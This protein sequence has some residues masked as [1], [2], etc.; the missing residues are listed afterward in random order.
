MKKNIL[1]IVLFI[2]LTTVLSAQ[3]Q[4]T[5]GPYG[6]DVP[7][8]ATIG[9]TIIAA[10]STNGF[11]VSDDNGANWSRKSALNTPIFALASSGTNLFVSTEKGV[12]ISTNKGSTWTLANTGLP[13]SLSSPIYVGAFE[14]KGTTVYA[15]TD[16]GGVYMTTNNGANWTAINTGLPAFPSINVRTIGK[17][18]A[19]NLVI[20]LRPGIFLS[21]N[22]GTTWIPATIDSVRGGLLDVA[23]FVTKDSTTFAFSSSGIYKSITNGFTWQLINN[24][25]YYAGYLNSV[26]V[27]GS[28]IFVGTSTGVY[29]ST[30]NCVTWTPVGNGL[31]NK[32]VNALTVVGTQMFAGTQGGGVYKTLNNG[33]NWQISSN[34][35]TLNE[36]VGMTKIGSKLFAA[37]T[38]GGVFQNDST[39]MNWQPM[40]TGLSDYQSLIPV[41]SLMVNGSTL[42]AG[43]KIGLFSSTN[44]A[45]TWS[46]VNSTTPILNVTTL[47]VT[48]PLFIGEPIRLLAGFSGAGM[49]YSSNNGVNWTAV[50]NLPFGTIVYAINTSAAT[51]YAGTSKGVL[52]SIDNGYNWALSNNGLAANT[53]VNCI[54][55]KDTNVLIGTNNGAYLSTNNGANWVAINNGFNGITLVSA[56]AINGGTIYAGT[57]RALYATTT[58]GRLW[59]QFDYDG[60]SSIPA[61]FNRLEIFGNMLY[62]SVNGFGIWRRPLTELIVSNSEIKNSNSNC[63]ISPNPVSNSLTINASEALVGNK[64]TIKNV[65]GET[66]QS[67]IL[68]NMSTELN[69][70]NLANGIY[71]LHLIGLNKSIKFVKE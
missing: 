67:D 7:F 54:A 31:S 48:K 27:N 24:G 69:V 13:V 64:Y 52:V 62:S 9:T 41:I 1:S 58:N 47:A 17:T 22:N 66:I 4:K 16:C 21:P 6:E 46:P 61:Y 25:S 59:T 56:F 39:G 65:L 71:F 33:N 34:G 3:W 51:L 70:Q 45:N 53:V 19:G 20:S 68:T 14:T 26:I 11:F 36:T 44:N 32:F 30:D 60:L 15:V 12:Y 57:G 5:N 18:I 10:T 63:T 2:C 29:V 55:V 42:Y 50:S 35:M 49:A 8:M 28:N 38:I 40:N 23:Y 43:T 37:M